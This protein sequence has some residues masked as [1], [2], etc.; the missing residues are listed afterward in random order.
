VVPSTC[1]SFDVILG[2]DF[3]VAN[4]ISVD[5]LRKMLRQG[6]ECGWTEVYLTLTESDGDGSAHSGTS[7]RCRG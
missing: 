1:L 2:S 5:V 4:R 7:V 6:L 3:L